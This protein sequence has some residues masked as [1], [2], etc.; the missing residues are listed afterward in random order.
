MEIESEHL[1]KKKDVD[2]SI[3]INN[4]SNPQQTFKFLDNWVYLNDNDEE[5]G[6]LG[7]FREGKDGSK[8][9]LVNRIS[10]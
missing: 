8:I 10:K 5:L 7:I 3:I 6:K 2:D 1:I 9:E 4:K